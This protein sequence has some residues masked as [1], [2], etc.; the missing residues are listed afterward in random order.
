MRDDVAEQVHDRLGPWTQAAEITN[1]RGTQVWRLDLADGRQAAVKV[2]FGGAARTEPAHE[3]AVIRAA[4]AAVG[5]AV[6]TVMASG[7]LPD[8][9]SWMA[10]PWWTG[11]SLMSLLSDARKHPGDATRA[12][13]AAYAAA[14]AAHALASLHDAGWAHGD[15]QADHV[16]STSDGV[17]L[18]D[19]VSAHS[20]GISAPRDLQL[21]Y[22]GAYVH[23]EPPE[24]TDSLLHG[25]WTTPTPAADVYALAGALWQGWTGTWP[26]D[27]EAAGVDPAPG[28]PDIKRRVIAAGRHRRPIASLPR[29]GPLLSRGLATDPDDRPSAREM[30]VALHALVLTE[31]LR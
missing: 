12:D 3:A 13:Q 17:R 15:V 8:G 30:T 11:P 20:D 6:G 25:R 24:I 18:I 21:P 22:R 7:H 16:I 5:P 31:A 28:T 9:G 1:R 19:L 14:D 29:Y 4:G 2:A 10:T 23:L 27:Y 26:V